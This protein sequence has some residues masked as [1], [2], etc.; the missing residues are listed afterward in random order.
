MILLGM[1]KRDLKFPK[2]KNIFVLLI[3]L[4]NLQKRLVTRKV[5]QVNTK[6]GLRNKSK[7]LK[8]N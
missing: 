2:I 8:K 7:Q 6:K 5:L 3:H 4:I 1:L